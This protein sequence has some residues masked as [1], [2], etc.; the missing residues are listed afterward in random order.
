MIKN[1]KKNHREMAVFGG[2]GSSI[3][4]SLQFN[5]VHHKYNFLSRVSVFVLKSN[6]SISLYIRFNVVLLKS[7]LLVIS[8]DSAY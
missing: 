6:S 3:A 8:T 2:N 7:C 4:V 5:I 1:G